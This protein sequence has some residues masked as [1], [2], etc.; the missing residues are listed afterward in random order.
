MPRRP[1]LVLPGVPLHL[2]QRGHARQRC[3]NHAAD[4]QFYLDLLRLH[5]LRAACQ[6]HAYVLMGNH[7]HLLLSIADAGALAA[8]MKAV[9]QQYAQRFNFYQQRTGAV[10]EGR[11]RSCLV[12]TER[13][14][15]LCQRYI[16]LNPVRA[17]IVQFAGHYR[18]S[19]YRCNAEGRSDRLV[20][21]HRLYQ[22][23]GASGRERQYA[24]QQ[25]F[26]EPMT[27]VVLAQ[28]RAATHTQRTL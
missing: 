13:Y 5:G 27:E 25:L 20:T 8:M 15:L 4:Y 12:D 18:W 26:R 17:G 7:V 28:I 24:Y 23:L 3:F 6:F 1:R 2:V 16:E 19:S 22:R 14:L 21:Q 11:Y 9:A 10:W